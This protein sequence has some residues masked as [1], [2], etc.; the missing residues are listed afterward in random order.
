[1][2]SL[3]RSQ[4]GD[5]VMRLPLCVAALS[6][7]GASAAYQLIPDVVYDAGLNLKLDV[8]MPDQG[9]GPFPLVIWI[10]GGGWQGGSKNN[11]GNHVTALTTKGYVVASIDY[12]LSGV[13][14]WP[15]QINDCKGAVRYLRANAG[16]FRIDPTRFATWGSSAGGHLSAYMKLSNGVKMLT[17]GGA[18]VDI[19]GN[20]GGNLLTS[21]DVQACVNYFG[22]ADLLKMNEQAPLGGLDHDSPQSPESKLIGG[23]IQDLP[24][25]TATAS[26]VTVAT[27]DDGPIATFHGSA[28]STVPFRQGVALHDVLNRV[29]A[30]S[31]LYPVL[32]AGHGGAEFSSPPVVNFVYA[33]FDKY[34]KGLGPGKAL[35]Q[36]GA[37]PEAGLV[38]LAVKLVGIE[39]FNRLRPSEYLFSTGDGRA[40]A[41]PSLS[42]T[43]QWTG[44]H[45]ATLTTW[46]PGNQLHTDLIRIPVAVPGAGANGIFRLATS[47]KQARESDGATWIRVY[48]ELGT[49]GTVG[50]IIRTQGGSAIGG[51]DYQNIDHQL[52]FAPGETVKIV[53]IAIMQDGQGEAQETF[54]V[55][56]AGPGGGARL[57]V[58]ATCSVTILNN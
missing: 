35:T 31:V 32:G 24:D 25:R 47:Q 26:P 49:Q 55:V 6:I 48:R 20:T 2:V 58:P 4:Q 14:Q 30:N 42:H 19:E 15:A 22:P 8:Y 29:G 18:T 54:N 11:P 51:L 9:Q 45:P 56:L 41:V 13:A 36:I 12:R 5:Y 33:F 37:N 43:Y 39:P 28:D 57:G 16:Q 17:V 1:M 44:L 50:V 23:A 27:P 53:K 7:A 34:L 3:R 21:S 40:A 46:G 52:I 10:H 38:P